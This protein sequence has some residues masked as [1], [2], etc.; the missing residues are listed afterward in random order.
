MILKTK[1][2]IIFDLESKIDKLVIESYKHEK[3]PMTEFTLWLICK[4]HKD[5][6]ILAEGEFEHC[7]KTMEYF[8]N[9]FKNKEST[10]VDLTKIL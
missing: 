6:L 8:H 9:Q 10:E 7:S 4:A 3:K 5:S 1:N 2:C